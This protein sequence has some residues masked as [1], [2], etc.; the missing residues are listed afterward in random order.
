MT[1]TNGSPRDV[2]QVSGEIDTLRDE[3]GRLVAEL[4]RRRHE[5]LD[6][7]LQVRRHP[8]V[9]IVAAGAAA[10]LLGGLVGMAIRKRRQQARP[11]TR[12]R[13]ARRAL[14]RLLDHPERVAAEPNVAIKIATA[15][16]V[17]AGSAVARRL[18]Q[19]F[20]SRAVPA[21]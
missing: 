1:A 20:V 10:L 9:V 11:T 18:A 3:L 19:R 4:D 5:L 21:R 17:A 8:G 16:G 12:V 14:A 6:V 13:E 2:R 7:K 15:A